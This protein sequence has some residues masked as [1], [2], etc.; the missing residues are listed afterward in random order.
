[1]L[2]LTS[3]PKCDLKVDVEFLSVQTFLCKVA[4]WMNPSLPLRLTHKLKM[5]IN[6]L[7]CFLDVLINIITSSRRIRDVVMGYKINLKKRK[8]HLKPRIPAIQKEPI[9]TQVQEKDKKERPVLIGHFLFISLCFAHKFYA[10]FTS[11]ST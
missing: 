4:M 9:H 2:T 8:Y 1:M 10:S 7:T 6:L 11:H 3:Y 5:H